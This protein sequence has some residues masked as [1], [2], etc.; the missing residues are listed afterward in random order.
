MVSRRQ[1]Q[2]HLCLKS[3]QL[4]LFLTQVSNIRILSK[5]GVLSF[6]KLFYSFVTG[7]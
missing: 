5:A 1:R 4:K 7:G 2:K 6:R 3:L